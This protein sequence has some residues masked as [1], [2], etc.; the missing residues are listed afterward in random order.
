ME[1]I[2]GLTPRVSL[3][4]SYATTLGP[5]ARQSGN[6]LGISI[7]IPVCESWQAATKVKEARLTME[8]ARNQAENTV[9]EIEA[10]LEKAVIETGNYYGKSISARDKLKAAEELLDASAL[11]YGQGLLSATDYLLAKSE[12]DR[13]RTDFLNARWQYNF[14]VRIIEYYLS[15]YENR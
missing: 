15:R 6:S 9:K 8:K 7:S 10:M 2:A 13:A 4:A 5:G 14:H 3:T 11:K 12:L 1:S